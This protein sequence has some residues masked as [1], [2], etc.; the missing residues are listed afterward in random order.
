MTYEDLISKV[1]KTTGGTKKSTKE[2][3]GV[4]V[5]SL[6]DTVTT[7]DQIL[8]PNFGR[9]SAKRRAARTGSNPSTGDPVEIPA[10]FVPHMSF[11]SKLKMAVATIPVTEDEA[12]AEEA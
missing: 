10:K 1:A 4:F 12:V 9:I 2:T 11:V 5:Q 7:G 8:I 6:N 3:I